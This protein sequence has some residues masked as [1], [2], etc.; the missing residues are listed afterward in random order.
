MA[1]AKRQPQTPQAKKTET[2]GYALV[3]K[4]VK[5]DYQMGDS[6][7]HAL[8][9]IDMRVKK[10]EYVAIM[11]P[12]GSGKS[13]L[14]HILGCL[15]VPSNGEYFLD[16][17]DVASMPDDQLSTIRN[18]RIGFVFQAFNLIPGMSALE[19][20]MISLQISGREEAESRKIAMHYLNLVGLGARADHTASEL[21]GGER[22]RVALARAMAN[23]PAFILADEPTGN[24]DSKTSV[25]VMSYIHRLWED[26]KVTIVMVT[27]EPVVAR[28]SQRIIRLKDGMVESEERNKVFYNHDGAHIDEKS[29]KLK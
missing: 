21:S 4:G 16:G 10:G 1:S 12:S 18:E 19:N 15:D 9:G 11:G 25:E 20:V 27:H 13:T 8:R 24:L 22:Q 14:L 17:D 6:Q 3:L 2:D 28:Y 5:K 23:D 29:I 26:H 7:V